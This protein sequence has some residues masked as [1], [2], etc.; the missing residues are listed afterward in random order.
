M[1]NDAVRNVVAIAFLEDGVLLSDGREQA[2]LG[3]LVPR[4][5]PAT[6]ALLAETKQHCDALAEQSRRDR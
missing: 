6:R 4:F 5:G 3:G 1:S 2:A